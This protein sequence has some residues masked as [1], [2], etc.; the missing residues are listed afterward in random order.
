MVPLLAFLV[1]W[2][3]RGILYLLCF[4]SWLWRFWEGYWIEWREAPLCLMLTIWGERNNLTF[5]GISIIELKLV[6]MIFWDCCLSGLL[7][8]STID[9]LP[10]VCFIDSFSFLIVILEYSKFL[11][12]FCIHILCYMRFPSIIVKYKF[13]SFKNALFIGFSTV[14][15]ILVIWCTRL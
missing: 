9:V 7:C 8:F 4:S 6:F 14:F 15:R 12:E 11:E 5:N 3:E 13:C 10:C 2:G 1:V